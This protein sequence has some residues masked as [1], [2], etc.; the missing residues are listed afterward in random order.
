MVAIFSDY[1]CGDGD[2][3]YSDVYT[4]CVEHL[5]AMTALLFGDLKAKKVDTQPIFLA[6][7]QDWRE[8][9]LTR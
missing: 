6:W 3:T 7:P 9:Y 5:T 8:K 1:D 2:F 4:V